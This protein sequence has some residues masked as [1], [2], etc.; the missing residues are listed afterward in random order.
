MLKTVTQLLQDTSELV[1]IVAVAWAAIS[2]K[3]RI[4]GW[5]V[6]ALSKR[7]ARARDTPPPPAA[8]ACAAR[9][10]S[11]PPQQHAPTPHA[12]AAPSPCSS[13]GSG[14]IIVSLMS[15]FSSIISGVIYFAAITTSLT[16]F[17][18][19]SL[20]TGSVLGSRRPAFEQ[21]GSLFSAGYATLQAAW[22]FVDGSRPCRGPP[23]HP[24]SIHAPPPPPAGINI[25]PLLASVGGLGLAVG[26]AT[27]SVA[28]NVVAA[29]S[30]YSGGP[31]SIGDLVELH[32]GGVLIAAGTV[33]AVEPLATT[34][35]NADGNPSE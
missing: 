22:A 3:D 9:P 35:R 32:A 27:Q 28:Q 20:S 13:D 15:P 23:T 26:L 10:S 31:F 24:A 4:V 17:G 2:F 16:A 7:C 30:L 6:S 11:P 34:L 14:N 18:A 21:A 29:V 8:T 33:T 25:S 12:L 19:R 5:M 1:V